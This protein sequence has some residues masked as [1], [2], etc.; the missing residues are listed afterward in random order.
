MSRD[1]P[2]SNLPFQAVKAAEEEKNKVRAERKRAAQEDIMRLEQEAAA[3]KQAAA[4]SAAAATEQRAAAAAARQQKKE[5]EARL[6]QQKKDDEL[7]RQQREQQAAAAAIDRANR[8]LA[9]QQREEA[10]IAA[11]VAEAE[12]ERLRAAERDARRAAAAASAP[13]P[14]SKPDKSAVDAGASAL[15]KLKL[16]EK[17]AADRSAEEDQ[18]KQEVSAV[19]QAWGMKYSGHGLRA[20]LG[21]MHEVFAAFPPCD[22]AARVNLKKAPAADVRKIY[23]QT[24]KHVHPD[25]LASSSVRDRLLGS[26]VFNL[27]NEAFIAFKSREGLA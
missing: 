17:E 11:A 7:Q 26:M 25:K 15:A 24:V 12:T 6:L 9:K 21:R 18:L 10:E 3:A 22:E 20:Y 27:L 5:E 1:A 19:V 2:P 16:H 4:E 23:L 13:R 8:R 14:S